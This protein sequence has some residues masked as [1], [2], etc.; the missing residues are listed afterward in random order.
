MFDFL[1]HRRA[2]KSV[3]GGE[4]FVLAANLPAGRFRFDGFFSA[5][6]T[7]AQDFFALRVYLEPATIP[8]A[9]RY[10]VAGGRSSEPGWTSVGDVTSSESNA[11]GGRADGTILFVRGKLAAPTRV[12][13]RGR[14]E[15]APGMT[16]GMI[17]FR[18][19]GKR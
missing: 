17:V 4:S 6:W 2:S 19:L 10:Y 1:L 8:V 12:E 3:S 13:L 14:V 16:L 18:L 15:L 5:E 7:G 9:Q 11:L